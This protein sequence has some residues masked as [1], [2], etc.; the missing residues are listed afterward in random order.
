MVVDLRA[1]QKDD[2]CFRGNNE[3]RQFSYGRSC[4]T[5]TFVL[6]LFRKIKIV[7]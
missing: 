2:G 3:D 4:I 1:G 5:L 7:E 6:K